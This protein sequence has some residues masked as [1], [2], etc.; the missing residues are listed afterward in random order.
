MRV[1][2]RANQCQFQHSSREGFAA[3]PLITKSSFDLRS[4]ESVLRR[5]C[6]RIEDELEAIRYMQSLDDVFAG[7]EP[8]PQNMKTCA[9]HKNAQLVAQERI[10]VY[11][12]DN[13]ERHI[14]EVDDVDA[15][16]KL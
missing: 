14:Q 9:I 15:L 5:E 8:F 1:P 10:L 11:Q 6:L 13:L 7:L 2:T 12:L 3:I 4:R 16:P